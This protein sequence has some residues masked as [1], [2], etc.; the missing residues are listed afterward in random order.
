MIILSCK[1]EV[2]EYDD[3]S[4]T[5][6]KAYDREGNKSIEIGIY[7]KSCRNKL[8]QDDAVLETIQDEIEW[9]NTQFKQEYGKEQE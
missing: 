9:M 6:I 2:E 7:C 8:K 5:S 1:C 3:T 4:M